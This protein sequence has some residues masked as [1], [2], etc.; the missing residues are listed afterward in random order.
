MRLQPF[1]SGLYN[2]SVV[3]KYV[4][5]FSS[6]FPKHLCTRYNLK[7]KP[8]FKLQKTLWTSVQKETIIEK[9]HW[10]KIQHHR[11]VHLE[12]AHFPLFILLLLL[13]LPD[14]H[15][16][17]RPWQVFFILFS[18]KSFIYMQSQTASAFMSQIYVNHLAAMSRWQVRFSFSAR[19]DRWWHDLDEER[20]LTAH[21]LC[22][23][24][25][26]SSVVTD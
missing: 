17:K 23:Q 25:L 1:T 4:Y 7:S 11:N 15:R 19:C 14:M 12:S 24:F 22:T 2:C 3:T 8:A 26:R 20:K 18:I 9:N 10:W 16:N 6:E 21:R 13:L 5:R